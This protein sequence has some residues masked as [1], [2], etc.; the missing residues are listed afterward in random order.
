MVL[1]VILVLVLLTLLYLLFTPLMLF[2]DTVNDQYYIKMK[3]LAK[4]SVVGDTQQIVKIRLNVFFMRFDIFPLAR[5]QKYKTKQKE[6]QKPKKTKTKAVFSFNK[7][8]RLLKAFKIKK[9]L[10]DIDTG[11]CIANAKLYPIFAL[12]NFKF[13]GFAINFD[14]RNRLLLDLRIR[15]IDVIRVF[16]Y[17]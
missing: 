4:A 7:G 15:S 1:A 13:G 3:G 2:V 10:I 14:G 17:D 11:D 8:L 16:I 6:E 12:L 5:A 9:F